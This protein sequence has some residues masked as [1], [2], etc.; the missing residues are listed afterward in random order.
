MSDERFHWR[1]VPGTAALALTNL[2]AALIIFD[3]DEFAHVLVLGYMTRAGRP[4]I[5]GFLFLTA[6]IALTVACVTRRWLPLNVGSVLSLFAWTATSL[7]VVAAWLTG[8]PLSPVGLALAV[9]MVGGQ[10]AMLITPL[11]ARGRGIV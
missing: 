1:R 8:A 2:V 10:A 6:G 4:Y 3:I 9:W 11:V 7:A 5:W